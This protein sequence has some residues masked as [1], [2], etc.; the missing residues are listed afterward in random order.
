VV[1][2]PPC[3]EPNIYFPNAFTPD[4]D[5]LN[6]VLYL[7]GS[8]VDEV[9]FVIYNRWGEKVFESFDQADGWDGT[10]RGQP[11]APDAYGYYL[12][13]KCI[14]GDDYFK[15]GNVTILK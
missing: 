14:G 7:Y 9:H 1:L 11:V 12:E 13:V 8:Q 6:D 15:K 2:N 4:G 10:F 3:Q 5:G